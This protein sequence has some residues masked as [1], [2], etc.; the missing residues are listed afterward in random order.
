M[1]K[2]KDYQAIRRW[3]SILG[4]Q[5]YYIENQQAM[6]LKDGAPITVIY[7]KDEG[8]VLAESI[9]NGDLREIILNGSKNP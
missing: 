2:E 5:N 8:W 7:K 4:S 1:T 9:V 3:G 6:A